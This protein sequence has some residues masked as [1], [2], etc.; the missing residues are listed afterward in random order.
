[1]VLRLNSIRS[2][3]SKAAL[4]G[5][6][7]R[8]INCRRPDRVCEHCRD[9]PPGSHAYSEDVVS[10]ASVSESTME[11]FYAIAANEAR[12]DRRRLLARWRS[13]RQNSTDSRLIAQ[14]HRWFEVPGLALLRLA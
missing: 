10:S 12:P 5:E 11:L 2:E 8:A 3:P 1:M 14:R 9:G 13:S 7:L 6:P 4:Y